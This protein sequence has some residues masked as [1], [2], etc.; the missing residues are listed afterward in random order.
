[1]TTTFECAAEAYLNSCRASGLRSDTLQN[2]S[3]VL[4]RFGESLIGE[5]LLDREPSP[6]DISSFKSAI[7]ESGAKQSTITQYM[8]ILREAFAWMEGMG[9]IKSSPCIPVIMKHSR[10]P[11][12][13]YRNLLTPA[14]I[15]KLYEKNRASGCTRE[16]WARNRAI[17]I[18]LLTGGVRNTELREL[19]PNDI[20]WE[21]GRVFVRDGKGGKARD[22][23]FPSVA[24]EAVREYLASGPRPALL[25]G[26]FPLFGSLNDGAWCPF[27]RQGLSMLVERHVRLVT[28]HAGVRS[29]ALRHA[30]ASF[31]LSSGMSLED[32][33]VLLGHTNVA[34]TQ[35]YAEQLLPKSPTA[36]ANTMFDSISP[37]V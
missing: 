11:K 1:M 27:T 19:N 18:M 8:N 35:R 24:A 28:G 14:E 5:N 16:L 10:E 26:D 37:A 7:S 20:D 36:A 15:A 25:S 34:V 6:R 3:A 22:V 21:H 33:Q 13:A 17:V 29:H 30:S 32:I 23:A 9:Y 4:R 2:Y 31:M 12:N